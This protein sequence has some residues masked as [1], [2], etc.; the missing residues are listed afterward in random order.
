MTTD[1]EIAEIEH[2]EAPS[3]DEIAEIE[4]STVD[5]WATTNDKLADALQRLSDAVLVEIEKLA[6]R[7]RLL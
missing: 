3:D 1:D 7:L 6:K 5:S 4:A 2:I